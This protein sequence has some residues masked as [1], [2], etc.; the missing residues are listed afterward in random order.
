MKIA[1]FAALVILPSL[2][3]A[4]TVKIVSP[5]TA[6]TYTYSSVT[7]RSFHWDA[8][9]QQFTARITFS[10]YQYVSHDELLDEESYNFEFPGVKFDPGTGTFF[11]KGSNGRHVAVAELSKDL[12]GQSIKPLPG[13]VIHV[14]KQSGKVVVILTGSN[15]AYGNTDRVHWSEENRGFFFDNLVTS[16]Y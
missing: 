10:N 11:A 1:L 15:I 13:T 3:H 4:N 6:Q 9:Q 8:A 16:N 5:D 7:W 14:L 2:L 12:I